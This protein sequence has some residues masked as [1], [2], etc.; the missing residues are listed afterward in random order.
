MRRPMSSLCWRDSNQKASGKPGAV[1]LPLANRAWETFV[2]KAAEHVGTNVGR[3]AALTLGL[4][5]AA[6]VGAFAKEPLGINI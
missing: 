2:L 5:A 4:I 6:I 3:G 1:Q